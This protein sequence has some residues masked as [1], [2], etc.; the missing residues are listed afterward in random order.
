[1]KRWTLIN[2]LG[3]GKRLAFGMGCCSINF[4]LELNFVDL[5]PDPT[6]PLPKSNP[7]QIISEQFLKWLTL[8]SRHDY[9]GP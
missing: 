5:D 4:N 8:K 6:H 9:C 3:L 7:T 2:G 1:M